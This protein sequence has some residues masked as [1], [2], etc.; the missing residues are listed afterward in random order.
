MLTIRPATPADHDTIWSIFHAVVAT[1]TTYAFAP[2]T[3]RA[4][5]LRLW[6]TM[7]N[8]TYV[9]EQDGSIVG[10]YF[11]KTNQPGL[12]A[13]VCNA[14]YMV[15]PTARRMG[16]GKAMGIHSLDEARR[17]GY[18]AMQFNFVV[19]TNHG[20]IKLWQSLGFAIV[21]TIPQAFRH[22]EHGYTDIHVMHR[23]L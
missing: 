13:H 11:I 9:A 14:G 12:G 10:T 17:L 18:R 19:A 23:L 20:A 22:A 21:G 15:A 6:V 3:D 5:A 1:G 4:E 2:N 8:T 7:P 16:I